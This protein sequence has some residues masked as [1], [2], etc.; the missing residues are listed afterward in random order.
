M[1]LHVVCATPMPAFC[2]ATIA[3]TPV[4]SCRGGQNDLSRKLWTTKMIQMHSPT[5]GTLGEPT[6]SMSSG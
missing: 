1:Q 4:R 5:P 2:T 3:M 6:T